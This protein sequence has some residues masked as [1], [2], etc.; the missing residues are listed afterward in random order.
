MVIEGKAMWA[1]VLA[2]NTTFEP[3]YQI[4]LVIEDDQVKEA[5]KQGLKVK[6]T[7]DGNVVRFRRKQF[8]KD[9]QENR[10]PVVVD[11]RKQ[12]VTEL[13]GNG[14]YVKVQFNVYEWSNKFGS[15]TGADLQGVQVIDLVPFTGQDGGEFEVEDDGSEFEADSKPAAKSST[16]AAKANPA[17][18]PDFDDDLPEEL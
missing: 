17:P 15:G 16:G 10:P 13:I 11:A 6:K 7:D 12:P 3:M 14:S 8:R 9:G 1:S 5:E 18:T 4:D 2:P